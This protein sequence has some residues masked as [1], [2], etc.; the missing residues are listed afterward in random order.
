ML[1]NIEPLFVSPLEPLDKIADP[2]KP[3]ILEPPII[4]TSPPGPEAEDIP[5]RIVI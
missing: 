5:P 1:I 3:K 4:F 2:P